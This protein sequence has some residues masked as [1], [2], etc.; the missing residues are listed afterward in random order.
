MD[1]AQLACGKYGCSSTWLTAGVTP[2]SSMIR[3]E[4]RLG[5]VRDADGAHQ[6]LLAQV[7]QGPPGLAEPVDARVRPVDQVQV[8]VVQT[9]PVQ[10]PAGEA[11]ASS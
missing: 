3:V 2:V 6:A 10:R 9:E 7:D 11:I 1:R 8:E 5:E 4:V